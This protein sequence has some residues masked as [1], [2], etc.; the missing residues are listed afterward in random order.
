M[1]AGEVKTFLA[2]KGI[3]VDDC[4]DA[5]SLVER[6]IA[7]ESQWGQGF[8]SGNPYAPPGQPAAPST[9]NEEVEAA[10]R[11]ICEA[12]PAADPVENGPNNATMSLIM[13]HGFGDAGAR[14]ISEMLKPVVSMTPGLR[15][16]FPQAP[17]EQ[18]SGQSLA[19]WFMPTNGQWIIDDTV[20][21]PIVA[22]IHAMVRREISRGV[23]PDQILIGGFAQGAACAARAALSFPDAPLGGSVLLSH[24][25]GATT[26]AVAPPNQG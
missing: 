25:F 19:S 21:K 17:V 24:F 5:E 10:W 13:L 16:L 15:L 23:Q 12:W 18:L 26:A 11:R 4:F 8:T 2:S 6:A 7:T 1:R 22:Y 9:G 20:A 14:F 3:R